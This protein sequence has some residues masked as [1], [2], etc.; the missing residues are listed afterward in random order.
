MRPRLIALD[1]D[2]TLIRRDGTIDAA[3]RA[4]IGRA[5]G[6]GVLVTLATGRLV[7]GTVPTARALGL[8]APLV[9]ADGGVIVEPAS[10]EKLH[11]TAI[12]TEHADAVLA[13]LVDH[14]LLPFVFAPDAIHGDAPR[15]PRHDRLRAWTPTLT[16]HPRLLDAATWRAEPVLIAVGVGAQGGIERAADALRALGDALAWWTFPFGDEWAVR[17]HPRD[18]SKGAALARVAA[19]LGIDRADVAAVGDWI[20]DVEMLRW[21]GR[22][23][24]MPGAPPDVKSAASD[25]LERGGV[26]DALARWLGR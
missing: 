21:A 4:A 16:L 2:G 10:G 14:A 23:F 3:D 8:S 20:N 12:D 6:E 22:S 11:V 24:A 15:A 9:C 25:P 13:R 19:R 17:V 26:A 18:C 1:M 5:R 7:G